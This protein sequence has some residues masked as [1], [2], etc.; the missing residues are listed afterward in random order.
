MLRIPH[1]IVRVKLGRVWLVREAQ[2][3]AAG[4]ALPE[5]MAA[6]QPSGEGDGGHEEPDESGRLPVAPR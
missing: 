5:E 1:P 4:S 6:G 2:P 3:G